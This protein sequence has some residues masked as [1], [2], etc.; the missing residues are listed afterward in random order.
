MVAFI[1]HTTKGLQP[2]FVVKAVVAGG[3]EPQRLLGVR[4][5]E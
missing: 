4:E 3:P 5:Q 2:N 1:K